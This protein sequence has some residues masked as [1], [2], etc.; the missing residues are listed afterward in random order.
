MNQLKISDTRTFGS[1]IVLG[2]VDDIDYVS[3]RVWRLPD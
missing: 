1:A 3:M 2:L